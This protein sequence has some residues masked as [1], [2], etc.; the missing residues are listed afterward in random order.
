MKPR[1]LSTAIDFENATASLDLALEV[2][3]YFELNNG[4]A[5]A[6]VAEVAC[7]TA[8]WRSAAAGFGVPA[9]ETIRMASAFEHED[10]RLA[11]N[12]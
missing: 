10:S 4:E 3:P 6:M 2:A 8:E 11:A 1:V 7:A 9:A 5:R 12:W